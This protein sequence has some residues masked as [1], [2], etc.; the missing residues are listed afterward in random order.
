M[1]NK[2]LERVSAENE[3]RK[4]IDTVQMIMVILTNRLVIRAL[5]HDKSKLDDAELDILAEYTPK[6]KGTTYGSDEYKRHLAAMKPMLDHHYAANRHHPE[7]FKHGVNDMNLLDLIEMICDWKAA[8][9]R[10]ADGDI[11]QSLEIN[12]ERFGISGQLLRILENTVKTIESNW[13]VTWG[14]EKS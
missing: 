14:L 2:E 12:A 10:H 1:E 4:H 11:K 6:L 13:P 8:T 3:T 9:L 7:H 5:E